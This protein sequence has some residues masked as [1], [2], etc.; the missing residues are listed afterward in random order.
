MTFDTFNHVLQHNS[1]IVTQCFL[2]RRVTVFLQG[3]TMSTMSLDDHIVVVMDNSDMLRETF[4]R[5]PQAYNK[6]LDERYKKGVMPPNIYSEHRMHSYLT[7][8]E[9]QEKVRRFLLNF[10]IDRDNATT[11][12]F[13][14][15]YIALN[16]F[17][18]HREFHRLSTH[19]LFQET[20]K[21][22]IQVS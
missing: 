1:T 13:M 3:S 9:R 11:E 2:C 8:S 19:R 16:K 5:H 21:L 7:P 6:I 12:R 15:F 10:L 4:S 17:G 14:E 18:F 22:R 20:A